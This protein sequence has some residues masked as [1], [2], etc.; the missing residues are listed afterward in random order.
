MSLWLEGTFWGVIQHD[1]SLSFIRTNAELLSVPVT[2]APA[3]M[4]SGTRWQQPGEQGSPGH[5]VLSVERLGIR[6]Q[7]R[8]GLST[9]QNTLDDPQAERV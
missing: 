7:S 3:R 8:L 5:H 9:K 1:L 2:E 4:S 6:Y